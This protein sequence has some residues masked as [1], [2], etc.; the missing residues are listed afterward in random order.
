VRVIDL[1]Y[2]WYTAS[3]SLYAPKGGQNLAPRQHL[4]E[5]KGDRRQSDAAA[6][7]MVREYRRR[8]PDKAVLCSLDRANG[9]AVL[10]AGG[11]LPDLP[12]AAADVA[13]AAAR[14]R[15]LE[16]H[17]S[18]RSADVGRIS[19]PST[20]PGRIGNP[21]YETRTPDQ[22]R[23][24][25]AGLSDRQWAL[26]EPGRGYLVYSAAADR[27]RLDLT[28][29]PGAFNAV[30]IDPRTGQREPGEPIQGGRVVEMESP[31]GSPWVLWLTRG[32]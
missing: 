9:W 8:Y 22:A 24:P 15:P 17:P 2:W 4:R 12:P 31:G 20:P 21:S 18:S 16:L 23:E 10:A 7:R 13:A 11:S 30:R 28:D 19:N 25:D 1:R 27:V 32:P 26:A 6:A 29:A 3:G 5:W 14:M